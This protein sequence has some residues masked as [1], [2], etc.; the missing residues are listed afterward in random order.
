MSTVKVHGRMADFFSTERNRLVGYVRRMINDAA[1]RDG[2]DIVQEVALSLFSRADISLP[3]ENLSAYVYQALRNRVV[4]YLR[5]KRDVVSFDE[6]LNKGDEL[7]LKDMLS[8]PALGADARIS[9]CEIRQR[10]YEAIDTLPDDQKA[11]LIETDFQGRSFRE[12]SQEWDVPVGT[13]LARK[14]RALARLR[15]ALVDMDI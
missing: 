6:P 4:D 11:V 1:D 3:I 10:I 2:E 8:D 13:L 15:T 9:E 14:S 5:R 12:L 7:S